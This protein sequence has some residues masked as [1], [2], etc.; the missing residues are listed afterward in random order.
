MSLGYM[1]FTVSYE[2]EY[3]KYFHTEVY[4]AFI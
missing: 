4:E 1:T 3:Q 2:K